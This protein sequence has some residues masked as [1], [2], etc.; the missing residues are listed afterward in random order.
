MR[1]RIILFLI[2]I[3]ILTPLHAADLITLRGRLFLPPDQPGRPIEVVLRQGKHVITRSA[4][5]GENNY[6]FA[7]LATG[8]YELAIKVGKQQTQVSVNLCCNPNTVSVVDVNLDRSSPTIAVSFPLE[9][10]DVV[11]ISELRHNYPEGIL[12]EF[13]KARMDIRG[14]RIGRSADRLKQ[15]V[16][17]APDFYSA[18]ALLGM[19]FHASGCYRDAELEYLRAYDLNP[20]SVQPMVNLGSL[21]IEAA[22]AR[23]LDGRQYLDEAISI[24]NKVIVM[25]PNS[26]LAYC[27]L[28]LAYFKK[29]SYE[30]AEENLNKA[31]EKVRSPAAAHLMMANV[32]MKQKK[33]LAAIDQINIYLRENP[34]SPDRGKIKSVRKE[35]TAYLKTSG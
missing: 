22:G 26:S 32:Y 35:I 20:K 9:P 6:E 14:G 16:K 10:S 7:N 27:L 12:K 1:G 5:D 31:L 15:A 30:A 11:D 2:S 8:R 34:F 23:L 19:V 29:E 18:R 3:S 21:Y 33:W 4:P 28:G 13:E 17:S 24:L 25:K